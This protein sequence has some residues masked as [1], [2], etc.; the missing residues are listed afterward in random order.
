MHLSQFDW[1]SIVGLLKI[2]IRMKGVFV[3]MLNVVCWLSAFQSKIYFLH[4]FF[5]THHKLLYWWLMSCSLCWS[6]R[7]STLFELWY[8]YHHHRRNVYT[9][10]FRNNSCLVLEKFYEALQCT[11]VFRMVYRKMCCIYLCISLQIWKVWLNWYAC[12][13]SFFYVFIYSVQRK[14]ALMCL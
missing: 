3:W 1:M 7:Y 4:F 13:N 8:F 11:T 14:M 6:I 9:K 2:L 10:T 12:W 5:N